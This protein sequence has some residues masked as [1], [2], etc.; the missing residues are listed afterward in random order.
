M[1]LHQWFT[2]MI[3]LAILSFAPAALACSACYGKSDSALAQGMNNGIFVLLGFIGLVLVGVSAFFVFIIR[4]AAR[5]QAET[6]IVSN[7]N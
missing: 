5:L 7:S 4:R 2:L 3:A 6:Q 1:K